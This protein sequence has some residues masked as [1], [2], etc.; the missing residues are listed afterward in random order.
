MRPQSYKY[1]T[2]KIFPEIMPHV[3][4]ALMLPSLRKN[5]LDGIFKTLASISTN[6]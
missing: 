4:K 6:N 5:L 3:R 2:M 1:I